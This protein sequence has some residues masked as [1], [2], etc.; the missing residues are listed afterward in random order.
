MRAALLLTVPKQESKDPV[1]QHWTP[2]AERAWEDLKDAIL[3]DPCIQ[4]FDHRKMVVLRTEFSSL[5][6]GFVLPQPG[7]DKASV[8]AAQD[9]RTGKRFSFMTKVSMEIL[10]PV[11]FGACKNCGNKVGL[12]L[13][14]GKGFSRD[15]AI[16]K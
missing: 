6:F 12:H 5:G 11:C 15:Y 2:D 10:W 13:H 14:L 3:L 8:K 4:R 9:Y 7:N 16:N 1:A